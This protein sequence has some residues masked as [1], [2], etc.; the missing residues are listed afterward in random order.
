PQLKMTLLD[1]LNKRLI[2]L[3]ELLQKL[4]LQAELV[5][6]RGED[7]AQKPQHREHFD[8]AL[9]RAVAPLPQLLEFTL[10]FVRVQGNFLAMKGPTVQAE[11]TDAKNA[12]QLLGGRKEKVINFSLPYSEDER[13]LLLIKK[14]KKTP[15]KYPRNSGQ[16]KK[17]PL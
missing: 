10:P 5:H 16:I 8:W 9:A 2:F 15:K 14:S 12:L 7:A 11:L 6:S 3:G 1:S 4:N 17:N 13:S